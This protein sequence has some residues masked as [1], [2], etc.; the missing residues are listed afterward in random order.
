MSLADRVPVPKC[1]YD[2]DQETTLEP[3]TPSSP[4]YRQTHLDKFF[5]DLALRPNEPPLDISD[6]G[7]GGSKSRRNSMAGIQTAFMGNNNSADG[8]PES[9]SFAYME[10]LL[11]SLTVLSKL[12]S[13]LDMVA[14]RLPGEI[15]NLVENT[16][17]EVEERAEYGRRRSLLSINGGLGKSDGV[18]VFAGEATSPD[19]K[20][21][22][23]A[24]LLRLAALES[25]SKRVE[26]EI[27]KD[28][29]WTL[30]SKLDAVAQGLRVVSEVANRIGSVSKTLNRLRPVRSMF[31]CSG[32]TTKT[33]RKQ[34]PRRFSHWRKFGNL[35]KRR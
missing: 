8:N 17:D 23:S 16:L 28:L 14:Q 3:A 35:C 6:T 12:G 30:Y 10:T 19:P 21:R 5:S 31:I 25:S 11:E 18:Y 27:L 9:D 34:N 7:A 32:G 26:H 22:L 29:F 2:D 1:D 20:G 4:S 24:S 33:R 15:F 13:A